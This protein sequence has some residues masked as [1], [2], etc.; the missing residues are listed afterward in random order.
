[1][2]ANLGADLGAMKYL[3]NCG[4]IIGEGIT[5]MSTANKAPSLQE[6]LAGIG[7]AIPEETRTRI[8]EAISEIVTSGAAVGLEVGDKA[9]DFTLPDAFGNPVSLSDRLSHGPVVVTFYRGE[10]CPYCNLQLRNLQE[11]V[12]SLKAQGA[13]L[14]AIS[15]QAPD[16]SLSITEKHQ[17]EFPVL[18]DV[19]QATISAY[20]IQFTMDGTLRD[21][22]VNVWHNDPRDKNANKSLNLPVPA[23]FVI[24]Q[25]GV[26]RARFVNADWRVR[27]EPAA[28][29][30]ALDSLRDHA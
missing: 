6:Q 24:D 23:T 15:P 18:S 22:H 13:T 19:D 16:H 26:V 4:A 11:I 2:Y 25:A 17:L 10:W 3:V 14:I 20:R 9:P 28:I 29:I 30:S 8:D 27:M 1:V 21:L 12:P 7:S 5:Q